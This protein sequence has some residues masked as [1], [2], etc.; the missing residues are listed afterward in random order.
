MF[1]VPHPEGKTDREGNVLPVLRDKEMTGTI[2]MTA[3]RDSYFVWVDGLGYD[4]RV[5]KKDLQVID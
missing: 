1:P 2:R 4:M 5:K 3:S